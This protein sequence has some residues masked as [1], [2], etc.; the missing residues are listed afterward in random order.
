MTRRMED[1]NPYDL[2]DIADIDYFIKEYRKTYVTKV[3][4]TPKK[5]HE[6]RGILV[7]VEPKEKIDTTP[8][9]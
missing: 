1:F 2:N 6:R 5:P 4:E 9:S 7:Y 3:V 8:R